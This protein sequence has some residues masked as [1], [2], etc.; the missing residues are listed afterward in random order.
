[1]YTFT[2]TFTITCTRTRTR[3]FAFTLA[4]ALTSP[5]LTSRHTN[6]GGERLLS[7]TVASCCTTRRGSTPRLLATPNLRDRQSLLP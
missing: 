4:V 5:H 1:M 3:T 6:E 7:L 2:F